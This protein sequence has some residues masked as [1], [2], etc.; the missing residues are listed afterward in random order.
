MPNISGA[1]TYNSFPTILNEQTYQ[2][3]VIWLRIMNRQVAHIQ[4]IAVT[5]AGMVLPR[6]SVQARTN[7]GQ[8]KSDTTAF[9]KSGS[10]LETALAR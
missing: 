4:T 8:T 5:K 3:T 1:I 9:P 10:G 6:F 7:F 2:S